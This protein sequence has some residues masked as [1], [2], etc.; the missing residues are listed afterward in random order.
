MFS[1]EEIM[2]GKVV[3]R[4]LS[5][6]FK[7]LYTVGMIAKYKHQ[8]SLRTAS[9]STPTGAKS[10]SKQFSHQQSAQATE[11]SDDEEV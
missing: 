6:A 11:E 9:A 2:S 10:F 1:D 8:V 5:N 7:I 3:N 4:S